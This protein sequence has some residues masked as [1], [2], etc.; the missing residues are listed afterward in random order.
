MTVGVRSDYAVS[1]D[2]QAVVESLLTAE[3]GPKAVRAV[4]RE[5]SAM[6]SSYPAEVVTVTLTDGRSLRI[7][8]KDLSTRRY[9]TDLPERRSREIGIYRDLFAGAGLG[10][11]HYYGSVEDPDRNRFWL[12][13]EYVEGPRVKDESF[14][15][16]V[17][18]A[19]WLGRM[20]AFVAA[21]PDLLGRCAAIQP[22]TPDFF[23]ATAAAAQRAAAAFTREL[24]R[25]VDKALDGYADLAFLMAAQPPT[26]VHGCY[27]PYN[28]LLRSSRGGPRICPVDW[29]LA[30]LGLRE[31]DLAHFSDGFNADRRRI[32]I[33]A[34]RTEAAHYGLHIE[35]GDDADALLAGCE[36][37]K[38]LKTLG[39]AVERTFPLAG[40]EKLVHIIEA[41]AARAL[42]GR[43]DQAS[44]SR[45]VG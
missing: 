31:Y 38:N 29:E 33:E 30:A 10:M 21:H 12:M 2:L 28:I 41:A 19:A 22:L 9:Y 25:R 4:K 45:S 44:R 6:A 32:L 13:L 40:V 42:R 27:R 43:P 36:L 5:A 34:Y 11:P 17:Q 35:L 20:Q 15:V 3:Y 23:V 24:G 1:D 37:H 18:A 16:W 39:K 8:L 26:L 7:L 14:E